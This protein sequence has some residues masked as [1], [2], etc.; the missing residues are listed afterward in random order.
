MLARRRAECPVT[1]PEACLWLAGEPPTPMRAC[2]YRRRRRATTSAA[3][4][5]T[6]SASLSRSWL[7][8][9]R[10]RHEQPPGE[11]AGRPAL[12]PPVPWA[13][14]SPRVSAETCP[15]VLP[16]S[17]APAV[18]PDC[19]GAPPPPETRP[20]APP[21]PAEV[22]LVL[23]PVVPP[24]DE[25]VFVV[26]PMPPWPMAKAPPAPALPPVLGLPPAPEA[27]PAEG[28]PPVPGQLLL[29]EGPGHTS[30]GIPSQCSDG[31]MSGAEPQ[32]T[33]C[34]ATS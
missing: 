11:L 17:D 34:L 16:T 1:G 5:S 22:A 6:P 28:A 14:G 23:V 18:P 25:V 32:G 15:P 24:P 13:V 30:V 4:P 33:N 21:P 2:A 9:P 8:L 12:A 7:G 29:S 20:P 19:P 10:T 27:P 26:W 3:S 31:P